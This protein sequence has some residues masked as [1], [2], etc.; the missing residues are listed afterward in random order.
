MRPNGF[1]QIIMFD[2]TPLGRTAPPIDV[3][4][5]GFGPVRQNLIHPIQEMPTLVDFS[6]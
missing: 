1:C 3:S 4:Q 2:K 6:D 5:T